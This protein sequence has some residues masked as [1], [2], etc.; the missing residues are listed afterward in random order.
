MNYAELESKFPHPDIPSRGSKF[1]TRIET[2]EAVGGYPDRTRGLRRCSRRCLS[3]RPRQHHGLSGLRAF[4]SHLLF[5]PS[6]RWGA[7]LVFFLHITDRTGTTP[8]TSWRLPLRR[9]DRS[10]C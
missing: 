1:R 2:G 6:R 4:R 7:H 5:S 9:F 8:T 10:S 3:L